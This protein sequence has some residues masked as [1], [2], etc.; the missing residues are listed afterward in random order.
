MSLRLKRLVVYWGVNTK[1]CTASKTSKNYFDQYTREGFLFYIFAGG[2]NPRKWALHVDQN[3]KREFWNA[4]DM[5][6]DSFDLTEE[7]EIAVETYM[8]NHEDE[9]WDEINKRIKGSR[10]HC[11]E[12]LTH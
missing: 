10:R 2:S 11:S 5:K 9:K 3:G 8:D 7:E 1:W 6:M 4:Q 12:T